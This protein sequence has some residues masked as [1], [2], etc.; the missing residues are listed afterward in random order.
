MIIGSFLQEEPEILHRD[1]EMLKKKGTSSLA[2]SI[3]KIIINIHCTSR[4]GR[5]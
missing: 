1:R 4:L 2:R 5:N 3:N